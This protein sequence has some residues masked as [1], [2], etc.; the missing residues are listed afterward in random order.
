MDFIYRRTYQGQLKLAIFDWAGTTVDYGSCAPAAVFLEGYRRKGIEITMAQ[1][2]A[3]MGL[4]KRAHLE[5]IGAMAEVAARWEHVHGRSLTPEDIDEMYD[6]FVPLMLKTLDDYATLIPG[7]LETV[8]TLR[9]QGIKVGATTGYFAEAASVVAAAAAQQGYTPDSTICASDVT[10]GRPAPWM[11]YATMNKLEVYPPAAVVSV[12]DTVP[13]VAS[14]LNAG[15][16]TVAVAK[17]G[18]ELGLTEA[19]IAELEETE[20]QLRLAQARERLAQAGAHY[21]I[22]GIDALPPVVEAINARLAHGER[23]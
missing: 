12:G 22:D 21:V 5:A 14:G 13:D 10:V 15:V 7:T 20:L 2:R 3:P 4:E 9:R 18:N 23:P 11:I 19:E 8:A 16:W 17:T 1:A 6:D